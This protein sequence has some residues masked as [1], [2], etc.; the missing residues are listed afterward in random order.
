[1][2]AMFSEL[3]STP[4]PGAEIDVTDG[5]GGVAIWL[6]PGSVVHGSPPVG[7]RAHVRQMFALLDQAAPTQPFW[8]LMFLG[9][10][11]PGAGIGTALLQHR[12]ECLPS[13]LWTGSHANVGFYKSR[14]FRTISHH[15]VD[16]TSTWW[17]WK[18]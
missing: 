16:G 18:S 5:I 14:G 10:R 9:A 2:G 3:V 1:M 13:A 11:T 8:Y 6:R 7:A 17:L 4:P 12:A 15:E